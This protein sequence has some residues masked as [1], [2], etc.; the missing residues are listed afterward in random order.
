M[1]DNE[2]V[3][4][5]E[6]GERRQSRLQ[7]NM[8]ALDDSCEHVKQVTSEIRKKREDEVRNIG[9]SLMRST[10]VYDRTYTEKST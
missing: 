9:R 7:Q 1:D 5:A 6:D 4:C 8:S 2:L 10:F 3:N